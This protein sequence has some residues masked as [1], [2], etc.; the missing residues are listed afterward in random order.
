MCIK[1]H[2]KIQH[3]ESVQMLHDMLMVPE[4][5]KRHLSRYSNSVIL[6]IGKFF[7]TLPFYFHSQS[8]SLRHTFSDCRCTVRS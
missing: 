3:A 7:H 4:E 8:A 6:S 5:W 2:S 1:E